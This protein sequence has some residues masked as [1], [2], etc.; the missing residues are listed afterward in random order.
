LFLVRRPSIDAVVP[1][2]TPERH[3]YLLATAA[4]RQVFI[5]TRMPGRPA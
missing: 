4:E 5:E 1:D 2:L 3:L